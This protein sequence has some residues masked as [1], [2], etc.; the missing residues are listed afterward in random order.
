MKIIKENKHVKFPRSIRTV[1][2]ALKRAAELA[3]Q[4]AWTKV[5]IIGEDKNK[6]GQD[7]TSRMKSSDMV[8]MLETSKY[9][10][11]K[12]WLE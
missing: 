12:D 11:L 4:N 7:L 1:R 3:E 9:L 8:V 10:C 5:V 2:G 6:N